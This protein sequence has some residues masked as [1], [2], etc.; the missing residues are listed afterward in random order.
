MQEMEIAVA[1]RA[2]AYTLA[3]ATAVAPSSPDDAESLAAPEV[4]EETVTRSIGYVP[5]VGTQDMPISI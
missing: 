5:P 2:A 3:T 1:A 4:I